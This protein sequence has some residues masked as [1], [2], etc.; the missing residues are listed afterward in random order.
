MSLLMRSDS[1]TPKNQQS[2]EVGKG[3]KIFARMNAVE[4]SN[5]VA[6]SEG[7][8]PRAYCREEIIDED[9]FVA[10]MGTHRI[11]VQGPFR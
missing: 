5:C 2:N 4:K 6:F 3:D 11:R 7:E 9:T 8:T 1:S 10:A